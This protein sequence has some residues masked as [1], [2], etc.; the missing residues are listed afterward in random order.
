MLP[1]TPLPRLAEAGTVISSGSAR[2]ATVAIA[3][4]LEA[5]AA[6]AP[7]AEATGA[8]RVSSSAIDAAGD[9]DVRAA[10]RPA[11]LLLIAIP[12][13]CLVGDARGASVRWRS[14]KPMAA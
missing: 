1:T 9:S 7:E 11:R 12:H 6:G 13:T 3:A 5:V 4:A 8:P 14:E 10:E 2:Q